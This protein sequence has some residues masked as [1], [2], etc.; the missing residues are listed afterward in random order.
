MLLRNK[1][2]FWIL[3]DFENV[4]YHIDHLRYDLQKYDYRVK[5]RFLTAYSCE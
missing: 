4:A 1:N 3:F 2:I 5:E